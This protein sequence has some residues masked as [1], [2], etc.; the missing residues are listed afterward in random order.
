MC[1]NIQPKRGVDGGVGDPSS[2]PVYVFGV[3]YLTATR[4]CLVSTEFNVYEGLFLNL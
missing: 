4:A 1:Y 2:L 3:M